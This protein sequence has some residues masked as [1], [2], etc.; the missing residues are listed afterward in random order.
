MKASPPRSPGETKLTKPT[1]H[2][3][4]PVE[5]ETPYAGYVTLPEGVSLRV[6]EL[7]ATLSRASRICQGRA[8]P[9]GMIQV[10]DRLLADA[11]RDLPLARAAL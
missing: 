8:V 11:E 5:P 7:A 4:Q 1:I 3:V 9:A 2:L 10:L 6:A